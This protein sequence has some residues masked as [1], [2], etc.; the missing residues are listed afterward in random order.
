MFVFDELFNHSY[1][2]PIVDVWQDHDVVS[3]DGLLA[4]R[5]ERSIIP[6]HIDVLVGL[7]GEGRSWVEE[8]VVHPF[9]LECTVPH[10][11]CEARQLHNNKAVAWSKADSNEVVVFMLE[12]PHNS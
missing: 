7:D 2:G 9:I 12:G 8:L 5:V 11:V 6:V 1:D 10:L 3:E 4:G